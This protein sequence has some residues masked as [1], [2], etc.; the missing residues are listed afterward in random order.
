MESIIIDAYNLIHK[1][2]ELKILLKQSQEVCVDS[3]IAKLENHFFNT[4]IK[5]VV[6]FDGLGKNKSHR[7]I[8]V[9]FA[10]TD[11]GMDYG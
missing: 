4:R 10:K 2:S 6:A 1:V 7:N 9:K 3:I 11:V 8:E 5:I